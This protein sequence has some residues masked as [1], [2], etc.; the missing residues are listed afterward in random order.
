[1]TEKP[2]ISVIEVL[3]NDLTVVN[4]ARVSFAKHHTEFTKGDK[5]LIRYLLRYNHWSPFSH[6][7]IQLRIRMPIFVARQWFKHTVGFTRN[8]VSR[9]YVKD[10]PEFFTPEFFRGEHKDK[11]QGSTD[12]ELPQSWQLLECL[13]KHHKMCMREYNS[14]LACG[15]CPEQARMVLPQTMMTEFYETGSLAAYLR[16]IGLRDQPDAQK[17]IR[18]YAKAIVEVLK[19]KFPTTYRVYTDPFT[20]SEVFKK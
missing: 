11:K 18:V 9:R 20:Y 7:Q 15:V 19:V 16:L 8:E 14:L 3:G 10:A 12:E 5:G 2:L 1:M 6:P 13:E 17:E 4:A